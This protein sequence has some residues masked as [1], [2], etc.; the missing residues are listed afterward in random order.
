MTYMRISYPLLGL[1]KG[2]QRRGRTI[3]DRRAVDDDRVIA[4]SE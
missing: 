4:C 3:G 2:G 1:D